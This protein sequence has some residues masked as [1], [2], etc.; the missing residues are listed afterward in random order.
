MKKSELKA[1]IREVVEEMS[2][3]ERQYDEALMK[4]TNPNMTEKEFDTQVV[5][6]LYDWFAPMF[7]GDKSRANK[8][9]KYQTTYNE[10]FWGEAYM[11]FRDKYGKSPQKVVGY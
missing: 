2:A 9:V 3:G 7:G 11:L 8:Q 4:D 10:D 6:N 5:K 1:L